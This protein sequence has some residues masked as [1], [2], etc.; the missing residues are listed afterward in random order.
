MTVYTLDVSCF[1]EFHVVLRKRILLGIAKALSPTGKDISAVH[2]EDALS[3]FEKP[4][5]RDLNLP[6]GI[7]AR[8]RYGEVVL[9][10]RN[11]ETEDQ[12]FRGRLEKP[13]SSGETGKPGKRRFSEEAR[14]P[15]GGWEVKLPVQAQDY[16][17]TVELKNGES[18]E[19]DV[20]FRIKGQEVPRNQYTKWLDYDKIMESPVIRFRRQGDFLTIADREGRLIHKTLKDYMITEKIPREQ[21]GK[22]PVLAVGSHVLWLAGCRISEY[23]KVGENTNHI[24]QVQLKKGFTVSETEE[25]N[26]G[27]H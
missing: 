13:G 27:T 1:L 2:V 5:N 23:F 6:F 14:N 22:I 21:R 9:E 18:L 11:R 7:C 25:E 8:R 16:P 19:F 10:R 12:R 26:V 17:V 3:L 20:F 24:L 15:E 4:G